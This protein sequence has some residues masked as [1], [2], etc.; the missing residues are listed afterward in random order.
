MRL[1]GRVALVTGA[2]GGIGRAIALTLAAEG[3]RV[4]INVHANRAGGDE[5]L[6]RL[7]AAGGDGCVLV[8]DISAPGVADGL[9]ATLREAFGPIDVLVNNSG[10]GAPA[11]A[12][13]ALTISL[14]DWDRVLAVNLRGALQMSRACLPDMLDRGGSIVN[15]ASIRGV[16]AARG[17]AA[18]GASK[19]GLIA[20]SQQMAVEYA[21]R[22]V[23]VNAVSPGFVESEMLAGY[24]ARQPDPDAARAQFAGAA[25]TGRTGRPDEIAEVVAFLAS[26]EASFVTGANLVA[27]GGNLA[28][29]MREFL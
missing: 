20:L 7:R 9:A 28:N 8:G 29:G 3:A 6:A 19:G 25:A 26:D 16:T 2:G 21:R 10:I 4:G 27:D 18:Y 1:Q 11:S 5:T 15:V 24:I 12:D 14:D 22:S 13:T 23:R 17:L